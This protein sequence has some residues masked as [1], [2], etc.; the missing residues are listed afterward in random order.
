MPR[1]LHGN[2][3]NPPEQG[4]GEC[5]STVGKSSSSWTNTQ[6]RQPDAELLVRLIG[7]AHPACAGLY[8]PAFQGSAALPAA[9]SWA[10]SLGTILLSLGPGHHQA[11]QWSSAAT[12]EWGSS[13]SMRHLASATSQRNSRP[14]HGRRNHPPFS[15]PL[16]Q[17][18]FPTLRLGDQTR[19]RAQGELIVSS[20]L[21][22]GDHC[23]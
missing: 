1:T 22:Q 11:H 5:L 15:S 12:K 17:R 21:K 20:P 6:H 3:L 7:R 23:H 10:I 19:F 8:C 9:G 14:K 18:Q 16:Q 13:C 4:K 2:R